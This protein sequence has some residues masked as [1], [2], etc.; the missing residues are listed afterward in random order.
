MSDQS[1]DDSFYPV[2][3]EHMLPF[4]M[5]VQWYARIETLLQFIMAYL[6]DTIPFRSLV[7]TQGLGYAGK[8]NALKSLLRHDEMLDNKAKEQLIWLLGQAHMHS[9]LRN[10]IAHFTWIKGEREDSIKPQY[11]EVRGGEGDIIGIDPSER[12]YTA[13]ELFVIADEVAQAYN[14]LLDFLNKQ[15]ISDAI[16]AK[17]EETNSSK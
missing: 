5:I 8:R 4:G 3:A 13:S 6:A 1:E 17:I 15:G 2:T 7:L 12:D 16:A 10:S 14:D 9:K 11:V